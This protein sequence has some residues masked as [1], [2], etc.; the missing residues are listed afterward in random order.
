M[1]NVHISG[2]VVAFLNKKHLFFSLV[3]VEQLINVLERNQRILLRGN[4]DARRSDKV[5][6]RV[7]VNL[8]NIEIGL[9]HY[10]RFDVFIGYTQKYFRKIGSLLAN[11]DK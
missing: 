7:H 2:L 6:Q 10:D 9:L 3:F 1:N 11:L 5:N 4:K 8:V